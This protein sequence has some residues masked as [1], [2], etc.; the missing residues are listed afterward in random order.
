GGRGGA[1]TGFGSL[2]GFT[3]TILGFGAGFFGIGFFAFAA[4]FGLAFAFGRLAAFPFLEDAILAD[5]TQNP[6]NGGHFI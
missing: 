1:L 2:T 4:A 5:R 6:M 3:G